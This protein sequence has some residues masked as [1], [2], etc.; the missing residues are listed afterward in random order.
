LANF[1]LAQLQ[2]AV[3]IEATPGFNAVCGNL[4]ALSHI[5][6]RVSLAKELKNSGSIFSPE[7]ENN[8]VGPTLRLPNHNRLSQ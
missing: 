1:T 5:L 6:C 3:G 8:F 2:Q 7:I 4:W